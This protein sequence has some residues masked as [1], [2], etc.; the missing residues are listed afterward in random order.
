MTKSE[1]S[2]SSPPYSS[3]SA[4]GARQLHSSSVFTSQRLFT[5]FSFLTLHLSFAFPNSK[6]LF[7]PTCHDM[8]TTKRSM[9]LDPLSPTCSLTS[10]QRV[11]LMKSTRKVAK[12]LGATPQVKIRNASPQV[13]RNQ[14]GVL[15]VRGRQSSLDDTTMLLPPRIT[16]PHTTS[17]PSSP[18]PVPN[19]A[20][21]EA[22][23]RASLR[24][25]AP[26]LQVESS[27]PCADTGLKALSSP[28]TLAQPLS[29]P[30][31]TPP[32]PATARR[33]SY[34][35]P[36]PMTA[37]CEADSVRAARERRLYRRRLSKLGRTFG[38]VRQRF[39][40]TN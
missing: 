38:Q 14:D 39:E 27:G 4:T 2:L 25:R 5:T 13:I 29:P 32:A 21:L 8:F 23:G 37:V 1:G 7:E 34:F 9:P 26:R 20:M 12:L 30:L 31:L 19:A 40:T 36:T 35:P 10:V 28:R 15:V 22:Q 3:L 6:P 24:R 17:A 16:A 33:G 11:Q 18:L